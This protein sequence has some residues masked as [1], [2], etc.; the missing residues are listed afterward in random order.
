MSGE[1]G[2]LAAFRAEIRTWLEANCPPEMRGVAMTCL[3]DL[4]GLP[5]KAAAAQFDSAP[6]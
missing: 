6:R 4:F 3:S 1:S 2:P 5:G